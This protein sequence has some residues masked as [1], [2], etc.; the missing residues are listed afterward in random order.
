MYAY[1]VVLQLVPYLRDTVASCGLHTSALSPGHW[2]L[3][4]VND[5][6]IS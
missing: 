1:V 5:I 6:S 3:I 2:G 4:F